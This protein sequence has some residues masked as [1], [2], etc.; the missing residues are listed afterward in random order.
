[1]L[2]RSHYI[3]LSLVVLLT[4]VIVNLPNQTTARL[5]LALGNLFLPGFGLARSSRQL[6]GQAGDA[7]VPRSELLRQNEMLL[8]KNQQ[9]TIHTNQVEEI[10]RENDRLRQ[11]LGWKQHQRWNLKLASVVLREPANWWRTVQIDLGTRD[12]AT[13]N[14]P[15][16]APDGSLV[17]RISS[18]SLTRSQVVLLG[19]P[20]LKVSARIENEARDLGVVGASGP[21]ENDVVELG[22]LSRNAK[23]KPGLPVRTSG[24]GGIFPRNIPIGQIIDSRSTD[25]GLATTAR[26]KLA[27][28][29]SALEEVW[30]VMP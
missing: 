12:G 21:L 24:D 25:S 17:G 26:V 13:N 16:L 9:L 19:D 27:A 11:L 20:N 5:K 10:A 2:K 3:A 22:Y 30:V 29:L 23:L 15:V 14:L 7:L 1:M 6:A 28:N 18:V 4:L 8:R